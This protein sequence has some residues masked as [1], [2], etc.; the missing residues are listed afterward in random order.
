MIM[1]LSTM[2]NIHQT[3]RHTMR[4]YAYPIDESIE[5]I[6]RA[7]FPGVD[8]SLISVCAYGNILGTDRWPELVEACEK[9]IEK[10]HIIVC[11][12]HAFYSQEPDAALGNEAFERDKAFTARTI[13][14][15]AMLGAPWIT[16]HPVYGKRL[17]GMDP[18]R[19]FAYNLDYFSEMGEVALQEGIGIAIENMPTA[20]FNDPERITD[21][22]DRL[23]DEK[24][25]GMCLDTGHANMNQIDIPKLILHLGPRL[26]TTHIQ[27]NHGQRDEHL[28][29]YLGDIEWEGIMHAL[30]QSGYT[31]A[32][33]FEVPYTTRNIPAAL[34]DDIISYAYKLG[35]YLLSLE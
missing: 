25:F 5:Y 26:K 23:N 4:E 35:K 16:L 31:G 32:F 18:D 12:A 17:P 28:L 34:H 24:L 8:L 3:Y 20:P 13:R 1:L 14:V 11:Q 29:P 22:L 9:A 30:H 2:T 19:V 27:D 33:N 7:G 6:A 15:A 10:T 21:L